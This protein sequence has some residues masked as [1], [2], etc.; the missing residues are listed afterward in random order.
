MIKIASQTEEQA[1][2]GTKPQESAKA[3]L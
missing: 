3:A 1:V 2:I